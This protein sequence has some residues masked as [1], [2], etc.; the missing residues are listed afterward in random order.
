M[1][2]FDAEQR[3]S[4]WRG[5]EGQGGERYAIRQSGRSYPARHLVS[6]AI[7]RLRYKSLAVA[8]AFLRTLGFNVV[9]LPRGPIRTSASP[10]PAKRTQDRTSGRRMTAARLVPFNLALA[11]ATTPARAFRSE[12]EFELQV[13]ATHLDAW[14]CRCRTQMTRKV[15]RGKQKLHGRIDFV[16]LRPNSRAVL[17]VIEAKREIRSLAQLYHA[18]HQAESYA[19]A[20][21][22]RHFVVAAP[23]GCWI[24]SRTK[25][26]FQQH[27][28]F[29]SDV[30]DGRA[31]LLQTKLYELVGLSTRAIV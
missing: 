6:T 18:A 5:W 21:R 25:R 22:L 9:E 17:T 8:V 2:Q 31:A 28:V 3:D 24:F 12:R 4:Y 19:R 1:S 13:I 30:W 26:A 20:L 7:E 10:Q 29:G 15:H 27:M 16:V 11:P 23:Q 14:G